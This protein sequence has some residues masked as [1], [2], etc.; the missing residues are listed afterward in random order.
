MR[1]DPGAPTPERA[2]RS[3]FVSAP[4]IGTEAE[5][6]RAGARMY[7]V[8]TTVERLLRDGAITPSMAEAADR[9]RADYELGVEGARDA[10]GNGGAPGW[11][12]A[13]ARLAAVR[14]YELA[15]TA[16]GRLAGFVDQIA[17]RDRSISELA[18]LTGRNRQEVAGICKLG[19]E[20]LADYYGG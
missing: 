12:Y 18:R 2:K 4:A 7:R 15:V 5:Q 11:Y 20:A 17:V 16:L 13:D 14:Q 3:A 1:A 6:A 8:L 9:L 10:A 19:L